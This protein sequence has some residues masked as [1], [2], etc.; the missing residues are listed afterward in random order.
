MYRL[1]WRPGFGIL[2]IACAGMIAFA[3]YHQFYQWLMP[4]LMCVYERIAIIGFGLFALLAAIFPPKKRS[5]VYV[6]TGIL[7]LWGLFGAIT[8]L[9]H[10]WMQY[11]PKDPSVSCASSLPFPIDLN[12]LPGSIAA[13]I[14]PVGDC[15]NIDFTILGIT[16]PIWIVLACL[17]LVAVTWLL[18]R[19]QL[20]EIRRNQ[21][22]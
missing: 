18:A 3:L 7:T 22:R 15:A 16:M 2:F 10:V 14:R 17:G 11:G 9:R 13:V 6:Y 19:R 5:G 4:C 20:T 12:A 1:G 21:W 8:G